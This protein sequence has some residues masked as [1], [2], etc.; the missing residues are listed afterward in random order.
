MPR[1]K[2]LLETILSDELPPQFKARVILSATMAPSSR[3]TLAASASKKNLFEDASS[4]DDHDDGGARLGNGSDGF[5]I[6][7][8]YARRFEHNK[9][10]EE[11][12]RCKRSSHPG[13]YSTD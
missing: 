11:K 1:Q 6:N 9:K 13:R 4:D 7:E 12:Q 10:R 5:R 2:V 8:D 3:Q